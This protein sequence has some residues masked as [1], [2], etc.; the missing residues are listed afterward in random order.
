MDDISIFEADCEAGADYEM[1]GG[2]GLVGEEYR[3]EFSKDY[4]D[5][6]NSR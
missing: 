6:I 1:P 4:R 3:G 2:P 5:R